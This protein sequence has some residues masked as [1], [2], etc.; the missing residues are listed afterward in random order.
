MEQSVYNSI[1]PLHF[2]SKIVGFALFSV[3]K[4]SFKVSFKKV[5]AVFLLANVSFVVY[6]NCLYWSTIFNI[7]SH[8]SEIFKLI[9]PTLAYINYLA[10][11]FVKVVSFVKRQK[12]GEFLKL[13]QEIDDDLETLNIRVDHRN[14]KRFTWKL[15]TSINLFHLTLMFFM[16][17]LRNHLKVQIGANVLVFSSHGFI[18]NLFLVSQFI[19]FVRIVKTRLRCIKKVV[20]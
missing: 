16:F 6:L 14:E 18:V 10:F 20:G 13:L 15:I 3:D 12:L 9:Y 1:R 8:K 2:L 5:D 4:K 19:T 7:N 17:L 11:N